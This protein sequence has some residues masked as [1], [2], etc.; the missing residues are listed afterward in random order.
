MAEKH[1]A[2]VVTLQQIEERFG[3]VELDQIHQRMPDVE[4]RMVQEEIDRR[5]SGLAKFRRKPRP[6]RRT[7]E[8][9]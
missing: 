9:R 1:V 3:I 6:A 2:D 4:G 5:A 7:V 8:A